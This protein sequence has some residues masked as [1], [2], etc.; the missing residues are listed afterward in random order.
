MITSLGFTTSENFAAIL[1]NRTGFR[2]TDNPSLSPIPLPLSAIDE[3]LLEEKFARFLNNSRSLN[4]KSSFTKMEKLFLLSISDAMSQSEVNPASDRTLL[5]ISTT[6]GNIDLLEEGKKAFF[7]SERIFLWKMSEVIG[8][9][10][11]FKNKPEIISNACISGVLAIGSA[12]RYL[13][14]GLYDNIIVSGGDILSGFVISG[15]QSFQALSPEPCK[16]YDLNR[17]GLSLGEGCGTMVL[18]TDE[19]HMNGEKILVKGMATSNDANHISG[20]SRTGE[21]LATAIQNAMREAEVEHFQLGY[22]SAHGTATPFNDEMESKAI[23][24]AGL[25]EVPINSFKGYWG[26]TL[27]AAGVLES[28]AAVQS[29]RNQVII[30]SAGYEDLGVPEEIVVASENLSRN[31][32]NL[33]KT[34]SG[35]GGCNAA[36][37]FGKK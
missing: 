27:G 16:P 37:V 6:K 19:N 28:I 14:S 21:E 12:F 2:Q 18:T 33:L 15:F 1:D 3:E 31:Y 36:V 7:E 20:P 23:A 9:F 5:I 10:F 30:K 34:A 17:T 32:N 26:H 8:N 11:G 13:R 29:M 4:A 24:L 22:V 25:K 35:F